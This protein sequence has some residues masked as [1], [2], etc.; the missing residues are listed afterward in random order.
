MKILSLNNVYSYKSYKND[1]SKVSYGS[2]FYKNQADVVSFCAK[3]YDQDSILNPTNHC[4]YCGC[5]VYNEQQI[6]GIAKE[7]L[8][9]KADR[10][11]GKIRSIIEKLESAKYSQEIALA[12]RLESEQEIKFFRDF[13]QIAAKKSFLRGDAIFEQVYS[14]N[15]EQ[16]IEELKKN[17]KPLLRTIDHVSPQNLEQ[18]NNNADINLVEAC[19]C[20]NHNIKK[21]MSFNEFYVMFPSI[22]NNMPEEKFNYAYSKLLDSGKS[23][24]SQRLSATNMLKLLQRLFIQRTEAASYLDSI[25]FRIKN[26]K[27]E[28]QDSIASCEEEIREKTLEIEELEALY[29]ELSKDSEYMALL[30]RLQCQTQLEAEDKAKNVMI[31]RRQKISNSM[32]E[33]RSPKPSQ[34]KKK[35]ELSPEQRE[36]KYNLLKKSLDELNRQIRTQEDKILELQ[37]QLSQLDRD[38][39]S[40]EILQQKK[41]KLERLLEKHTRLG[42]VNSQILEYSERMDN[43]MLQESQLQQK[44]NALPDYNIEQNNCTREEVEQFERYK[45]LVDA[46]NYI[47]EHPNGGPIKI[48]INQSAKKQISD[49]V[50]SL[51]TNTLVQ[52]FIVEGNRTQLSS[53]LQSITKQKDSIEQQLD[54]LF[55]EKSQLEQ[56][57]SGSDMNEL[58]GEIK[59]ISSALRR[60]NEKSNNIKIPQKINSLKTEVTLLRATIADLEKKLKEIVKEY[61]L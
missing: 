38:F 29:T 44:I 15:R 59:D 25:D 49:E 12:K 26:S 40:I 6:D 24:I 33:L 4:A 54:E 3:K 42:D 14:M 22:Q 5:K 48:L 32:N 18:E 2:L 46:L 19:Y 31:L 10:L 53:E 34:N 36:Q 1:L 57:C 41:N 47:S 21:G 37:M 51:L 55:K 61:S 58:L 56:E 45:S 35:E 20:C 16:A 43:L 39:P 27:N 7:I 52:Q 8:V 9:S 17:M 11:Q 60:L 13:S 28:I 30:K 23:G 50:E